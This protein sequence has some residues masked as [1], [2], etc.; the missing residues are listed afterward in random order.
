MA[1][2]REPGDVPDVGEDPGGASGADA[3]DVHQVRSHREDRG[4]ELGFHRL[5]LGVQAVQVF[6]LFGGHPA[7]GLPGQVTGTDR[8]QQHLVLAR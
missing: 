4:L 5:E 6:Q 1:A 3:M 7:A 8:G 2:I